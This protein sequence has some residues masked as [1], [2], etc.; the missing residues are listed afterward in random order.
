MREKS[1][2]IGKK[3]RRMC[4]NAHDQSSSFYG[5]EAVSSTEVKLSKNSLDAT[6][7]ILNKQVD[8]LR[9]TKAQDVDAP[10][11]YLYV[12]LPPTCQHSVAVFSQHLQKTS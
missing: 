1:V 9:E 2:L 11:A 12:T 4:T 3:A 10:T 7:D 8:G 6:S 5:P